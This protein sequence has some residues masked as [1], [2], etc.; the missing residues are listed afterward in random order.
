MRHAWIVP[1]CALV[2]VLAQGCV[3]KQYGRQAELEPAERQSLSCP[4]IDQEMVKLDRYVDWV[5]T[6][7]DYD[8]WDVLAI[9]GDFGV[10][11]AIERGEALKAA[12]IRKDQLASLRAEKACTTRVVTPNLR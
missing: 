12:D 3:T 6:R 5:N 4:G 11:N 7:S 10:G 1:S 2:A 8:G 9:L